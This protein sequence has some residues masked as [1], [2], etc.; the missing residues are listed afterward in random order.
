MLRLEITERTA[1]GK[2]TGEHSV[3]ANQGIVHR[4][5][6]YGWLLHPDLLKIR[7]VLSID[8]GVRL[9]DVT[10]S[11]LDSSELADFT[12]LVVLTEVNRN[13][14]KVLG[15][16]GSAVTNIDHVKVIVISHYNVGTTSRLAV[17]QLISR[18]ELGEYFVNIVSIC[19]MTTSDDSFFNICWEFILHDDIVVQVL[20]EVFSTLVTS[21]TIV[22]G[23][24]LNLGPRFVRYF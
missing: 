6:F 7:L 12:W 20:L 14:T 11:G 17:L 1:Y 2:T 15:T 5:L 9:I 22:N 19:L 4:V 23:K 8:H 10:T 24:Y 21:M 3:W 18:L 16:D 13:G